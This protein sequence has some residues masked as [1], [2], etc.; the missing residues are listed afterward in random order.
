MTRN[1]LLNRLVPMTTLDRFIISEVASPTAL[2]FVAYTF[3]LLMRPIFSLV[4]QVFVRGLSWH[5]AF[6]LFLNGV[7]LVVVLSIPMS[8]LFGVLIAMGRL[9]SDNEI[10]AIQAGGISVLRLLRPIVVLSLFFAG[11]NG[12]L[13]VVVMP[14]S[15]ARLR[16]LKIELFTSART[17]GRVEPRIFNETFPNLLLYVDDVDPETGVWDKVF[18]Y[19]RT[20]PGIE[21]LTLAQRGQVVTDTDDD[22][23][24]E[25]NAKRPTAEEPET[26]WLLLEKVV[27]HQFEPAK[28]GT[29][30]VNTNQ[31]QLH[32]LLLSGSSKVSYRE[33]MRERTTKDLAKIVLAGAPEEPPAAE[34]KQRTP[35]DWEKA[36]GELHWRFAIPFA[37]ITFGL[38][39]LPIG[40]GS[41]A[42]GRGRGFILSIMLIVAYWV[43]RSNAVLLATEGRMPIWLGEWIANIAMVTL[44]AILMRKMGRWLGE[45]QRGEGLIRRAL[46]WWRAQRLRRA[47]RVNSGTDSRRPVTGSLP[48]EVQRR[49][50]VSGFPTLLDRYLLTRLLMPLAMVILTAALLYVVVDVSDRLEDIGKNDVSFDVILTYYWNTLPQIV[51][52][53]MPMAL[54]ISVLVLL[55]VLERQLELTAL[56]AA[57]ISLYRVMIPALCIAVVISGCL[58]VLQEM[59][60]PQA[61]RESKRLL[62]RIKGRETTRSYRDTDRQWLLARDGSTL[63]NFRQFDASSQALTQLTMFR[64]DEDFGLRFHLF[65]NR[66]EYDN[67]AWIVG[68]G[69]G[70]FRQIYPDG[71]DEYHD[72]DTSLEL[73]VPE[74]PSYFGQEYRLPAEMSFQDLGSYVQ[75]LQE[76]GYNPVAL[77]VRWHQKL[78]YPLSAVIMV[79]LA[80]PFGLNRGGQRVTTMQGVALAL[81]LGIGYFLLVAILGKMAEASLVAPQ[82]GAWAPVSIAV[83]FAVNRM[84]TL[85]S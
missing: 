16:E 54:L 21:R 77:M 43:L 63:Y 15:N 24:R 67:G 47:A 37:C 5:D 78:T 83:L 51:L 57:G 17:L 59:V 60:V 41:R 23:T 74:G 34:G 82:L 19:D 9:N 80:L 73:D 32:K 1:S 53:V 36:S 49:R 85:R 6:L 64:I 31:T 76:S 81:A 14:N 84:T 3:F 44:A 61:N 58:W 56:K 10:I 13:T 12:Y 28:P 70:W 65:A 2:G 18:L 46:K 69:T 20:Q 71:T 52:D 42:G 26:P 66:A 7:P 4:E 39:A 33:G 25:Q 68:A 62:D 55:T 22:E 35:T 75:E 29:Y 40:I 45:R 38:L 27:T 30:R 8:F 11:V 48:V 72:I 50:Y 79:L